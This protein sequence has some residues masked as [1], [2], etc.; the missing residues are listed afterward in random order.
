MTFERAILR[1]PAISVA[2][3]ISLTM[4]VG[5]IAIYTVKGWYA[6]DF[7]VYWRAANGSLEEVYLPREKL[8]FPYPPTM[9]LWIAPLKL[10]P[11]W[12]GFALWILF[13][14][15]L[16]ILACRAFLP[17]PAV[18]LLLVTPP[19]VNCFLMGQVSAA[20]T[21]VLLWS[22]AARN[23]ICAGIGFGII[24]SIKPQFVIMVPLF[25]L[26]TRD[27]RALIS[28]GTSFC[29]IVGISLVVFGFDLWAV[30]LGSLDNF[31]RVLLQQNVLFVAIT[32]SSVAEHWGLPPL[33]FLLGGAMIGSWL[34]FKCRTLPPLDQ[35][36]AIA[37][38]SLLAAPYALAY[39]LSS[40]APF[41]VACALRGHITASLAL[42]GAANPAPL[43]L[44]AFN[45]VRGGVAKGSIWPFKL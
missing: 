27:W 11:M 19:V 31:H 21:A 38:G 35:S 12:I 20:L 22:C 42:A 23:R 4:L 40:I 14:A 10:M 5:F 9:L 29:L 30:W 37:T 17:A 25:F 26:V 8:P 28:S 1:R 41:L 2:V 43:L 7:S 18:A 3:I 44:S 13:S 39:D 32:P 24:A 16:L 45:L 34:I 33:P 36:A 6:T 15:A